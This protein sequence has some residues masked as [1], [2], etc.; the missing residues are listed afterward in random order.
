MRINGNEGCGVYLKQEGYVVEHYRLDPNE[1]KILYRSKGFET[2][3]EAEQHQAEY[4]RN[5]DL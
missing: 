3:N 4:R 5:G 2:R 1:T